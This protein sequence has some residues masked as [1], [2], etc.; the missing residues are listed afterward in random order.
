MKISNSETDFKHLVSRLKAIAIRKS[1][2]KSQ[3]E[4]QR[5]LLNL[6]AV[7]KDL[8]SGQKLHSSRHY[9]RDWTF[10]YYCD[11]QLWTDDAGG[12]MAVL[13]FDTQYRSGVV[14]LDL[15]RGD[16]EFIRL[17]EASEEAIIRVV[18]GYFNNP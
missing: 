6:L 9:N 2:G 7:F 15:T 10:G 1:D 18:S 8:W 5:Y 4:R 11:W 17:T 3:E 16:F 13:S 12:S 14:E